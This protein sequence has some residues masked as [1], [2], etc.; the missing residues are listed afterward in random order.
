MP[1]E[2]NKEYIHHADPVDTSFVR[3]GVFGIEDGMVSTLGAITGIATATGDFFTVVLAGCVVIAVESIAMAVGSYLSSK[4]EKEI[5]ERMLFEEKQEI[6]KFPK[7]EEEEAYE[8]FVEDGWSETLAKIMAE[9][10]GKKP[11]LML[12]E[13]AYRELKII[14]DALEKPFHNA[15]IMGVA[16]VIGGSIPLL[17]YIIFQSIYTALPISIG[18]TLVSLFTVGVITT[19]FSKRTWWKAGLEMLALASAAAFIGWAVGQGVDALFT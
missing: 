4:S 9:E 11:D 7:E 5:D 13:M 15:V 14:P 16:Y 17:P 8:M 6:A 10:A 1:I 12:T 18:V 2:K 3:E 19:K